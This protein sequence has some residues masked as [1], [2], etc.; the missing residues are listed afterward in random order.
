MIFFISLFNWEGETSFPIEDLKVTFFSNK[1][2]REVFL[3]GNC[4]YLDF[5]ILDT[6]ESLMLK[7]VAIC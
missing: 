5:T 6:V 4:K 3:V 2:E 7:E 1:E